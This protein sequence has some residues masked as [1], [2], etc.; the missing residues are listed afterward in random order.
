M[1]DK[2]KS[3]YDTLDDILDF[4]GVDSVE[5]VLGNPDNA[6]FLEKSH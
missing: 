4:F 3:G 6:K 2:F 1:R 5:E